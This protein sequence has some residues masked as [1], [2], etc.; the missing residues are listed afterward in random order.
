MN[1]KIIFSFIICAFLSFPLNSS[2]GDVFIKKVEFELDQIRSNSYENEYFMT[3][4]FSKGNTY[5]FNITNIKGKYQGEVKVQLL[6]GS[7]LVGTNV[8]GEDYFETFAFQCNKTGYYDVL[9]NFMDGKTGHAM[10]DI[11]IAQ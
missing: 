1:V 9:M 6:D 5:K 4:N 8:M 7:T 2:M 10:L 11:F 3:L